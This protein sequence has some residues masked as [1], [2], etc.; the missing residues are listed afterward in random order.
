MFL[1]RNPSYD[2]RLL[3]SGRIKTFGSRVV[4]AEEVGTD[5]GGNPLWHPFLHIRGS[6]NSVDLTGGAT[7]GVQIVGMTSDG[8]TVRVRVSPPLLIGDGASSKA[9]IEVTHTVVEEPR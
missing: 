1:L 6:A 8:S 3:E 7:T 2:S 4:V 5:A 9:T